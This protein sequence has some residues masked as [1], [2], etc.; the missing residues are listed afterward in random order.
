MKSALFS[1]VR[2]ECDI[3]E[4]FVRYHAFKFDHIFVVDH[5]S[6]DGT[7]EI[8]YSLQK[9]GLPLTIEK[10]NSPFHN[11]GQCITKLMKKVR[12]ENKPS[13]VM[14]IDAD[15]FVVGDIKRA[16]Y[17]L[18]KSVPCTLSATWHNYVPTL[19]ENFHP[20]K[21]ICYRT[22]K[23][24]SIQHKTLVPGALFDLNVY[25]KEGCH[26]VYHKDRVFPL[27]ASQHLHLAHFPIRSHN[28]FM[29]KSLVGWI[30]K[31]ANPSN[32]GTPPEWSHWKLFFDK[33]KK[34]DFSFL[35]LQKLASGYTVDQNSTEIDLEYDP[36]NVEFDIKYPI[37]DTYQ[38]IEA[39][40]DAAEFLAL[41][42]GLVAL[43]KKF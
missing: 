17:D 8:L 32:G 37:S 42:F 28:Q 6:K 22:K 2:N 36:L 4:S 7:S 3:I 18:P 19:E 23:T 14:A 34:Q 12:S 31:L 33:A 11:Q 43:D 1:V 24:N 41:Q 10:D 35:D 27:I 5:N 20:L 16:S 30:S 29:K 13:V 9:E 38:P 39:L 21:T 26:E 15:E 40:A 25:M